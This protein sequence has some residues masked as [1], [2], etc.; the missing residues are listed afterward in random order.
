MFKI[1][2]ILASTR[3]LHKNYGY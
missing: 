3:I 2:Q 1:L